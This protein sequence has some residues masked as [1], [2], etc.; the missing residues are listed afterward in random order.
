MDEI[1][2]NTVGALRRALKPYKDELQIGV[3]EENSDVVKSLKISF[4]CE[5]LFDR[6]YGVISVGNEAKKIGEC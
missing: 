6:F 2:I 3:K 1:T 5:D 4:S